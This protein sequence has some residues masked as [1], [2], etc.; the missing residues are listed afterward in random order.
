MEDRR[1]VVYDNERRGGKELVEGSV[2]LLVCGRGVRFAEIGSVLKLRVAQFGEQLLLG[3]ESHR[4]YLWVEQAEL[5][6]ARVL[7]DFALDG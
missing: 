3:A 1:Q 6:A 4:P 7:V 5:V 2:Y